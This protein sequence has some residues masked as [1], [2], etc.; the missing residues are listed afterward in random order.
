[1][2]KDD[3]LINEFEKS[4][5]LNFK[6]DIR[7][8]DQFIDNN[9][10][11]P[12]T[13]EHDFFFSKDHLSEFYIEVSKIQRTLSYDSVKTN[14]YYLFCRFHDMKGA[15]VVGT[16]RAFNDKVSEYFKHFTISTAA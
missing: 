8:L 5:C 13:K 2:T 1:M 9:L 6:L 4:K 14:E 10:R 16:F 12:V 7:H 11:L 15:D 3:V